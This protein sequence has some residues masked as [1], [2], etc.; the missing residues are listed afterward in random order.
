MIRASEQQRDISHSWIGK[1][2]EQVMNLFLRSTKLQAAFTCSVHFCVDSMKLGIK[3]HSILFQLPHYVLFVDLYSK[4]WSISFA[5]LVSFDLYGGIYCNKPQICW[6]LH[7]FHWNFFNWN[8]LF[9]SP[10]VGLSQP[11]RRLWLAIH[12]KHSKLGSKILG[13]PNSPCL[14]GDF[15]QP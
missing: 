3:N 2:M 11:I 7:L 14:G 5:E 1:T 4:S 13:G 9:F 12:T 15:D 6:I 8:R 10:S